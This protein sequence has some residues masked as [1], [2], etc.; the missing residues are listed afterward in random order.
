MLEQSRVAPALALFGGRP[1][2]VLLRF[3]ASAPLD[4][5]V[6]VRTA[7][8]RAIR[9][10]RIRGARPGPVRLA[11]D[12]LTA[13]GRVAPDG[14]YR[15]V[16]GAVGGPLRRAGA[17]RWRG[18]VYPVRGPH[19]FRGPVGLFGVPRSGGRWH[20]GFDINAACGTPVVASRGGIVRRRDYDPVLYGNHV[21]VRGAR[22]R[23]DYWYS[24]LRAPARVREGANVRTGQVIGRVGATGNARFVGCHLHFEMRGRGGPFDP[25]PQ[26]LRWDRWS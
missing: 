18:H 4:L 20:E 7:A 9:R 26:L 17:F 15:I 3:R 23:R 8:G 6:R 2:T 12:G 11:W 10:W 25:L 5:E 13:R 21:I 19:S 1:L 24:H 14:R 22:E 16:A